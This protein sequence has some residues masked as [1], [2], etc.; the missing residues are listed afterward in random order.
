[1]KRS[2]GNIAYLTEQ[3]S[4]ATVAEYREAIAQALS[5][6]EKIRMASSSTA[7][8]AAEP[9]G[10]AAASPRPTSPQPLLVLIVSIV[11][12][13]ILGSLLVLGRGFLRYQA[14]GDKD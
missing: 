2:S 4:K 14:S 8:F 5:E 6:Q 10:S 13:G 7:P 1:L 11:G 3:L 12:G 9:F